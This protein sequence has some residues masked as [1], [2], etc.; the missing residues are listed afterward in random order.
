MKKKILS[1]LALVMTTMTASATDVP[2]FQLIKGTSEHGT[3]TFKVGENTDASTAQEGQ[4]VTVTLTPSE[5]WAAG[6]TSGI[7]MAAVAASRRVAGAEI[8][9]LDKFELTPVSGK[10]NQWTFTM[11]RA[12]AKISATYRKLLTHADISISDIADMTYNGSALKPAVTVKDGQT[13]LELDKDYTVTYSN[14][15]NAGEATAAENAPTATITG[16]GEYAG[17]VAKTF[18]IKKATDALIF[19]PGLYT[20]NYG[21]PNFTILPENIS[22]GTLTYQST[23][24]D[25]ATVNPTTGEVTIKGLG[26]TQIFATV[27]A[28]ANYNEGS[29]WYMLSVVMAELTLDEETVNGE[30]LDGA[31]GKWYDVTLTRSL[32]AGMWNTF[33]VPFAV[34]AETLTA[35]GI[36]AK[37]LTGSSFANGTL[38]LNFGDATSLEAGKPYLVKASETLTNPTFSKVKV[39]KAAVPTVTSAV[40]FVP[41]LGKT[42]ITG[43]DAKAVLF[44]TSGNKLQYPEALPADFKGFRAYFQLKGEAT[45]ARSF[46][47]NLGDDEVTGIQTLDNLTISPVDNSVYDLQG[48]RVDGAAKRGVYVVNGKKVIIK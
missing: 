47:L 10:K 34:D 15:V 12:D 14:N 9:L 40:D 7:W 16:I 31:D 1:L 5:G 42:E 48:R 17:T 45:S 43:S 19:A 44:L 24:P 39:S 25:V 46:Q 35:M 27:N 21:D 3:I 6:Q 30:A 37:K 33:A 38:T 23:T 28:T 8:D 32:Q 36:T 41:T 18:T 4:T 22:G 2:T 29:D 20:K 26:K 11:E 13:T